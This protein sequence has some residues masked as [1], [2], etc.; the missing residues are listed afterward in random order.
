MPLAN[1]LYGQGRKMSSYIYTPT[2]ELYHHGIKG[3]KWGQRRYQNSDGSLT[4]EGK[5]RYGVGER[6]KAGAR[7]GAE[8]GAIVGSIGGGIGGATLASYWMAAGVAP[9]IAIAAGVGYLAGRVVNRM[10][11]GTA[12]G[13]VV[14]SASHTAGKAF[15]E[16]NAK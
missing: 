5:K 11:V 14:G 10:L 12:V 16:R 2:S 4:E 1:L 13:A 9:E 15:I 8:T 7:Y 6:A 3:Q